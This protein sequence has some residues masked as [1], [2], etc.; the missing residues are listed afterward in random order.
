MP[1]DGGSGSGLGVVGG[2]TRYERDAE[3]PQEEWFGTYEF[4]I[5]PDPSY[6]KGGYRKKSIVSCQYFVQ[7]QPAVCGYW[8]DGKC[9]Y[10]VHED[11]IPS[12]YNEGHC[13]YLGR[14]GGCSK[15]N[16][17]GADSEFI[18]VA[19]N[20]FLSGV[21][22]GKGRNVKESEI[23]GYAGGGC[24]GQGL[25]RGADVK[26]QPL[27]DILKA[28]I[29]CNY[30][31]PWQMSVGFAAPQTYG[32]AIRSLSSNFS[33]QYYRAVK[34]YNSGL[35]F[36]PRLPF[37]FIVLNMRSLMQ[38]CLYWDADRGASF[39]LE[40]DKDRGYYI[41]L[42]SG[43]HCSC[44]KDECKPYTTLGA[45]GP[46]LLQE[47]WNKEGSL[48]CNGAHTDCPCYSGDWL[49][50]TNDSMM[51]GMR[52][53]ANQLMELR[54]WTH[55]WDSQWEYDRYFE[56]RPN[57]EDSTTADLLTFKEYLDADGSGRLMS[58]KNIHMCMPASLWNKNY[59][60][61]VY[62]LETDIIYELYSGKSGT[63][64]SGDHYFPTLMQEVWGYEKFFDMTL[65][66]PFIYDDFDDGGMME[67]CSKNMDT[68]DRYHKFTNNP[69]FDFI[70]AIGQTIRDKVLYAANKTIT[71]GF[72]S[73]NDYI[74][75]HEMPPNAK[76]AMLQDIV[77][78]FEEALI[79]HPDATIKT[80]TD[81]DS[82]YFLAAPMRL[83]VNELNHIVVV[84]V[85]GGGLFVFKHRLVESS[86]C[87]LLLQ[88]TEFEHTPLKKQ[89]LMGHFDPPAEA[90]G[91]FKKLGALEGVEVYPAHSR[92]VVNIMGEYDEY[93]YVVE[94]TDI[95]KDISWGSVGNSPYI[96][97]YIKDKEISHIF[98]WAITEAWFSF[99]LTGPGSEGSHC[100]DG[101]TKIEFEQVYPDKFIKA[102]IVDGTNYEYQG[103]AYSNTQAQGFLEP[104]VAILR[105]KDPKDM[106]RRY[107][108]VKGSLEI[109]GWSLV[110]TPTETD[111]N[112]TTPDPPTKSAGASDNSR[113][114]EPNSGGTSAASAGKNNSGGF[115]GNTQNNVK[116]PYE[117][118]ISEGGFKVKSL[119]TGPIH[120]MGFGLTSR[121][122]HIAATAIKVYVYTNTLFCRSVEV[123]H[124]YKAIGAE[125][126]LNPW[127]GFSVAP[128]G[129]FTP[130]GTDRHSYYH[131]PCGDHMTHAGKGI[132]PMWYPY[133]NCSK[134]A[135]YNLWAMCAY[136]VS[137][138]EGTPRLDMR[139]CMNPSE[140]AYGAQP[141]SDWAGACGIQCYHTRARFDTDTFSGYAN[142]VNSVDASEYAI[143]N[144]R[145]PPFGNFNR[146][147]VDRN[148][149]K[150][151]I[152]YVD[153]SVNPPFRAAWTP[154]I[155][156]NTV[157]YNSFNAFDTASSTN[158]ADCFSFTDTLGYGLCDNIGESYGDKSRFRWEEVFSIRRFVRGW[159][160]KPRTL[161]PQG[162]ACF[163]YMFN[164]P[165]VAWA[166]REF[167]IP[168]KRSGE[169][170]S[171]HLI[172]PGYKHD[173]YKA[174]HRY[175]TDEGETTL[176]FKP[177]LREGDEYSEN[178]PPTF[179]L[180]DGPPR[181]FEFIYKDSTS[182]DATKLVWLD[183]YDGEETIYSKTTGDKKFEHDYDTIFDKN[184]SEDADAAEE[185]GKVRVLGTDP[186]TGEE[187]KK[188]Y[189]RGVIVRMRKKDILGLPYITKEKEFIDYYSIPLYKDA[190]AKY[191]WL[192]PEDGAVT[193][194]GGFTG[195]AMALDT[196]Y[197]EG[198]WGQDAST[199][200]KFCQP[201][202]ELTGRADM[203]ADPITLPGFGGLPS[204]IYDVIGLTDYK[205]IIKK[206]VTPYS[207]IKERISEVTFVLSF[208]GEGLIGI[209]RI[210]GIFAE[211]W[212]EVKEPITVWERKYFVSTFSD[213]ADG[214]NPDT[215]EGVLLNRNNGPIHFP[216][217]HG[218]FPAGYTSMN[219][220]RGCWASEFYEKYGKESIPISVGTISKVEKT[221]QLRE[222][223]KTVALDKTANDILTFQGF[224]P[225]YHDYV[226]KHVSTIS[227]SIEMSP[228]SMTLKCPLIKW[229][230]LWGF[231]DFYTEGSAWKPGGHTW[232]WNEKVERLNCMVSPPVIRDVQW[233]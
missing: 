121:Q 53:T 210:W 174:E 216:Y 19:P 1:S 214:P 133:S 114:D 58:G 132:G 183:N 4:D 224:V 124:A 189:N 51:N 103:T 208:I 102:I 14:R 160:P 8:S 47:V 139:F 157:F 17:D 54:F 149:C 219:K 138:I 72:D 52:V 178:Y 207:M 101:K 198:V 50:C 35:G 126:V 15:Y 137:P 80:K 154:T 82:G 201:G 188:V 222:W 116:T 106:K 16:G 90:K 118:I 197:I 110:F 127:E 37:Y 158:A 84:A 206:A 22:N 119:K 135:P 23:T 89:S 93:A 226:S 60:P 18:C 105:P 220:M 81:K 67:G 179:A 117:V 147:F 87:G 165:Q 193:L 45:G 99:P 42:A 86:F 33:E 153:T 194:E 128:G 225:P 202:I 150:D 129:G 141:R 85:I 83:L 185:D 70:A 125:E 9:T 192:R 77:N 155:V 187:V 76:Q 40:Y 166:W 177:P 161:T 69:E 172:Q 233:P 190:P 109:K 55:D 131:P 61:D 64:S 182:Y 107:S 175:I 204:D 181:M 2:S 113:G 30:Y 115:P 151:Y 213:P 186:V 142:L 231:H 34:A 112:K 196:L 171:V 95:G 98:S 100:A 73:I 134:G 173:I 57:W 46:W 92:H 148:L 227:N 96:I 44:K 6:I 195:D 97:V 143:H 167:W 71:G 203:S 24:D 145:M 13:D 162:I 25:G 56:S 176:T 218:F 159:Y 136:C 7:N 229:E 74:G 43:N 140:I 88:Q 152:A 228:S 212:K 217:E 3:I 205:I 191:S 168:I 66:Y 59:D 29:V 62:I 63:A 12:G 200:V 36:E 180:G 65:V 146:S 49:Y 94:K 230:D 31:R 79:N 111:P 11:D 122:R 48:I 209:N 27:V 120:V 21:M 232:T 32:E 5:R 75:F 164:D 10:T 68:K 91:E 199:G 108:T 38:K 130:I 78:E 26:G 184:F 215:K 41:K 20:P 169:L 144:W 156:D 39:S 211:Q 223:R 104:G 163:G 28:P 221:E 123:N 170:P